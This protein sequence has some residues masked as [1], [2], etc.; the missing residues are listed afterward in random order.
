[1]MNDVQEPLIFAYSLPLNKQLRLKRLYDN[2][3]QPEL[4]AL[5]GCGTSTISGIERGNFRIP[6]KYL[7]K[8]K[9]YIFEQQYEN[10]KLVQ[11]L[12]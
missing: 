5:I 6:Y 8:V 2:F 12:D 11:Y 7:D 10:K 3:S 9:A 1:M 4:A